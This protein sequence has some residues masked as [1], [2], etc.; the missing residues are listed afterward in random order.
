MR[1]H[2]RAD[3]LGCYS[4]FCWQI[5]ETEAIDYRHFALMIININGL[6]MTS[7]DSLHVNLKVVRRLLG[8]K[9][10]KAV[11]QDNEN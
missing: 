4:Y 5:L 3:H 1:N 6:S 2:K 11:F 9:Y 10:D 8:A 7:V